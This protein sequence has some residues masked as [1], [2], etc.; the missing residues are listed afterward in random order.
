VTRPLLVVKAAFVLVSA[1]SGVAYTW[2]SAQAGGRTVTVKAGPLAVVDTDGYL[3]CK[4]TAT[5]SA[6][7]GIVATIVTADGTNVTNFGTSFRASPAA[8]GNGTYYAEETAGS[9]TDGSAYCKA[10]IT[11]ARRVH[12]GGVTLKAYDR[13]GTETGSV[14][15]P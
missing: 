15:L 4:V 12:I 3:N 7:I 8:T 9:L 2:S 6:P 13:S 14:T 5:S 11:S 1:T 10:V